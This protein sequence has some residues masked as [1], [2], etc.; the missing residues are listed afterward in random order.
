MEL[1]QGLQRVSAYRVEQVLAAASRLPDTVVYVLPEL[2]IRDRESFFE[3]VRQRFP[4]D[5]PVQTSHSWAAL[6]DSMW[7]GIDALDVARVV[8]LWPQ[9]RVMEEA[10]PADFEVAISVWEDLADAL[11]DAEATVGRPKEVCVVIL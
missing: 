2:G 1:R 9:S 4:L 5:P 6:E 10:A 3:A 8:I 11:H 7:S